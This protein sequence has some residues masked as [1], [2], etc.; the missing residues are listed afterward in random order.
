MKNVQQ[1]ASFLSQFWFFLFFLPVAAIALV[2]YFRSRSQI[3]F[4]S[5]VNMYDSKDTDTGR[6]IGDDDYAMIPLA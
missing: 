4:E 2:I 6:S 5:W 3:L 1:I